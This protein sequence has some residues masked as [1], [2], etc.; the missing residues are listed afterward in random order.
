MIK[1]FQ[2]FLNES[3][4]YPTFKAQGEFINK[5]DLVSKE[6]L[7]KIAH[8]FINIYKM[9]NVQV[10]KIKTVPDA[11]SYSRGET[12]EKY[13]V[14]GVR[15][16][17]SEEEFVYYWK[18]S[19]DPEFKDIESGWVGRLIM[20][21]KSPGHFMSPFQFLECVEMHYFYSHE[22]IEPVSKQH[23]EE[24]KREMEKLA[25]QSPRRGK[26]IGKKYGL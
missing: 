4:W 23:L 16:W 7:E 8:Y 10:G 20:K 6:E 13:G 24:M 12:A 26:I 1:R 14:S 25:I 5:K 17:P 21:G 22:W 9:E 11:S 3:T 19:T 2:D 15:N 18:E